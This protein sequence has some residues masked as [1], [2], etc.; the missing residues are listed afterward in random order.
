M[1]GMLVW[2]LMM[3]VLGVLL[4]IGA[5]DNPRQPKIFVGKL[6][7]KIM[8]WGAVEG[9]VGV[10]PTLFQLSNLLLLIGCMI[11]YRIVGSGPPR[12]SVG[13]WLIAFIACGILGRV[14]NRLKGEN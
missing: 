14:F 10:V 11:E 4:H 1:R 7:T 6:L 12:W 5:K 13:I 8:T 2:V 9:E 3:W